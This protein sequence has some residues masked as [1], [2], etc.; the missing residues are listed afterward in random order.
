MAVYYESYYGVSSLGSDYLMHHG[1]KGM[2]WGIRR[3][4]NEDGSYT[5]A[6][7]RRRGIG[8]GGE[9]RGL[10]DK[11]KA[12]IKTGLKVAGVAAGVGAAAY[13]GNKYGKD[14][15]KNL[16][17]SHINT[18]SIGVED[19]H[20]A[21]KEKALAYKMQKRDS[22]L[23]KEAARQNKQAT[24]LFKFNVSKG[25]AAKAMDSIKS[26]SDDDLLAKIGRLEKEKRLID[27]G[28][29]LDD[30]ANKSSKVSRIMSSAGETAVKS[31][32]TAGTVLAAKKMVQR[33]LNAAGF[34]GDRILREMYP[35]KK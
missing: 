14:A 33:S 26:L 21:L 1:I 19:P 16:L 28:R 10:S 27:L 18:D 11:T 12:R 31:V 5:E 2:K 8:R 7:K 32:V 25:K 29:E 24:K 30:Y 3:F 6:G 17:Y 35:K 23:A 13:L 15:A 9:R 4:Q 34:D 20:R 22:D